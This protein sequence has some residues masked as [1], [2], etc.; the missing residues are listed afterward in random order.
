MCARSRPKGE[1]AITSIKKLYLQA[2]VT[3]L[4]IDH[5]SLATVVS[6]VKLFLS[7]ETALHGLA[8]NA[9]SM[10]TTFE[11]SKEGHEAQWQQ[12]ISPT[13]SS[14]P[15]FYHSCSRP[16]KGLP[17]SVRI[18]NLSSSSHYSAQKGGI[19]FSDTSLPDASNLTHYSQSKLAHVLH[20]KTL[21]QLYEPDSPS[22]A[23]G[24]SEI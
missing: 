16:R 18:V 13:G 20:T 6:S 11:I 24:N 19:N 7:K 23:A 22:A 12:T 4:E 2:H 9:G 5:L 14:P 21:N 3:R 15:V 17:R 8:N 1:A 10:A